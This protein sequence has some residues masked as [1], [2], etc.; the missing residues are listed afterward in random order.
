MATPSWLPAGWFPG[1]GLPVVAGT[2]T[3]DLITLL[4]RRLRRAAASGSNFEIEI[5]GELVHAQRKLEEGPTLPWFLKLTAIVDIG[6]NEEVV[7]FAD[8]GSS[9]IRLQDD[10]ALAYH[11]PTEAAPEPIEVPQQSELAILHARNP[12]TGEV[13]REF[14]V[15]DAACIV[16]PI[17]TQALQ[18]ALR[19]YR[20]DTEPVL[21][22]STLWMI[23]FPDLIMNMAGVE[24]AWSLRDELATKRF[25]DDLV[26]ARDRYIKMVAAREEAG[27][28]HVMGDP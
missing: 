1:A 14:Y 10:K 12:G 4:T 20:K 8:T 7:P 21:A 5:I 6:A 19:F 26:I 18:Y 23:N 9:V 28:S 15:E 17:P 27:Q 11:D 16:R 13:P 25:T 24:L 3:D 2:T 22:A